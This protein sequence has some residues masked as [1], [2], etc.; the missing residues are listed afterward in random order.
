MPDF[1]TEDVNGELVVDVND[2]RGPPGGAI[3]AIDPNI[4]AIPITA[5]CQAFVGSAVTITVPGPGTVVVTATVI[6][7]LDHTIGTRD[8]AWLSVT[9][10]PADCTFTAENSLALVP[11]VEPTAW[12]YVTVPI[13]RAFVAPG[14]GTYTHYMNGIMIAGASPSDSFANSVMIAVYYPS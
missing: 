11:D 2:C 13:L 4:A 5:A 3:V 6:V 9:S 12:Y 14:S 1:A 7:R 8:N 10:T